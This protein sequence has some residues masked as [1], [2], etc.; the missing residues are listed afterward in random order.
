[1]P[2]ERDYFLHVLYPVGADVEEPPT[3]TVTRKC[4]WIV[5]ETVG[6][7]VIFPAVGPVA[8]HIRLDTIDKDFTA[9][10]EV[11]RWE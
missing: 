1:V 4:D 5:L 8:G 3:A 7:Q 9:E 10:V 2:A 6:A 11:G